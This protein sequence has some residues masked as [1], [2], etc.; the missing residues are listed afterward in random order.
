MSLKTIDVDLIGKLNV[1]GPRYTSYPTKTD[2]T[3]ETSRHLIIANKQTAEGDLSL[4]FYLP[5]CESPCD[6]CGY[7]TVTTTKQTKSAYYLDCF[8]RELDQIKKIL[9]PNR[10]VT[11]LYLGADYA[12]MSERLGLDFKD[13]CAGWKDHNFKAI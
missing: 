3:E 10:K 9:H 2:F 1:P 12:E 11:S 7:T 13:R 4:Y 5:V 8:E 6:C